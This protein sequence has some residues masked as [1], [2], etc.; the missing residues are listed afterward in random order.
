MDNYDYAAPTKQAHRSGFHADDA[1]EYSRGIWETYLHRLV[2]RPFHRKIR[3]CGACGFVS[4]RGG[5][6][7]PGVMPRAGIRAGSGNISSDARGGFAGMSGAHAGRTMFDLGSL[8]PNGSLPSP[9][10][11]A[12]SRLPREL[13]CSNLRA[14]LELLQEECSKA[15]LAG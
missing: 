4:R 1:G 7:V 9:D 10:A 12:L 15:P 3:A 6:T 8:A 14:L 5:S 11:G 2:A 13:F